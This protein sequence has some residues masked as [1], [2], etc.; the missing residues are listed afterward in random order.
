MSYSELEAVNFLLSHVGAAPVASLAVPLPDIVSA[1]LRLNEASIW[2]Q[3]KGWWFNLLIRQV[4]VPDE[5]TSE[6]DLPTNTLKVIGQWPQFVIERD[7]KA[8]NPHEDSFEWDISLTLDVILLL[9]WEQ[10]PPSA[11]DAVLYR[12]AVQMIIHELEDTNKA[13]LINEDARESYVLL[14]KEDLEIR[15][16]SV[17]TNPAFQKMMFKVR[18]Y[19][20]YNQRNPG[21]PGGGL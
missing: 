14:K 5:F 1:Q 16:R 13:A 20:R 6:I 11:Q 2:V 15:Q 7:D 9:E 8:Y 12:A 10:L 17:A 18:P 3:K 4:F 21:V 19:K